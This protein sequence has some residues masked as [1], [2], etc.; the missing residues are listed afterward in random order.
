MHIADGRYL[1]ASYTKEVLRTR[2]S[3]HDEL[4][5]RTRECAGVS[6]SPKKIDE[7][8]DCVL[9]L[10]KIKDVGQVMELIKV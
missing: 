3:T 10:E 6:L 5:K 8:I 7:L 1:K 4:L 9:S 2:N